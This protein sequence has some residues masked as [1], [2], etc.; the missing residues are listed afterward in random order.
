[1]REQPLSNLATAIRSAEHD[2]EVIAPSIASDIIDSDDF[3]ARAERVAKIAAVHANAVDQDRRFPREAIDALRAERLLGV[4][5]PSSLG[6]EDAT[7]LD[8]A[9]ICYALGRA[10]ASTAMIFAMHQVKAACIVRH[11]RGSAWMDEMMRKLAREQLLLASSTTEGNAGGDVRSSAAPVESADQH[12]TLD[13]AATVI[14]YGREADG[15]VTTAR[16]DANAEKSDQ[17][18]LVLLKQ[19]YS[20]EPITTWD[21]LGM[22]GTMSVGFRLLARA[23][24]EQIVPVTYQVIHTETMTPT[25]HLFWSSVWAG[26][27][28][29]A[30][31]K[32][33][34][35][36]RHVM[37]QS[38][39]T[40]PPGAVHLTQAMSS[41]KT[42]RAM[43][44][45]A[46]RLFDANAHDPEAMGALDFQN[47]MVMLKIDASELAVAIVMKAM[48]VGGLS[49]YRQDGEFSIGRH[50]RDI[51]SA[52]VMIH[53]DRILANA[54]SSSLLTSVPDQLVD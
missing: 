37:R 22:R 50:L 10:C 52:P 5:V 30:V 46:A 33:H 44:A 25:A 12:I 24:R 1:M 4:L 48:R 6:G 9:N 34:K 23:N 19:D 26:I 7:V 16:R 42:L 18:L 39:G 15:I 36:V 49:A 41:L 13:R 53:N 32:A 2:R 27:A 28:A 14:S 54:V 17:V 21:T 20:L 43:I 51:L 38:K 47:A 11:G 8:V 45:T 29:C 31:D 40:L 3:S 35:F